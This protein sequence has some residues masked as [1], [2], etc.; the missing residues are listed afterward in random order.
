[1]VRITPEGMKEWFGI[2]PSVSFLN[3]T[4]HLI[5]S[6]GNSGVFETKDGLVVFD[7]PLRQFARRV[8][9]DIR[10]RTQKPVKYLIYSHGHLDHAFGYGP[11][12][13]EIKEKGWDEP[14]VIAHEN[15]M[16]RF[17]K[18]KMLDKYHEW[19]NQMQFASVGGSRQP[20][21]VSSQETLR[22]TVLIKGNEGSYSFSLGDIDF[23]I[24][25]DKGE[26]DDSIWLWVPER[27]T[28]CT[29]DLFISSF[30]NV[31]NPYKVQRYPKDWALALEKM[32]ENDPEFLIPGHGRLIE[33]ENNIYDALSITAEALLFVHDE[34]VN[35]LNEG[36]W[37]EQIYHEMLEIFPEKFK[38]RKM[39]QP[40]YGCY[41][42]AIHA[43]YRLYHG[44][45]T[46]GNPTDLFPAKSH[47]IA[48]E[49]LKLNNE[50][51][52]LTHAQKLFDQ[53]KLQ[54]A[55]HIIDV[56]ILSQDTVRPNIYLEALVLKNKILKEKVKEEST[57][58]AANIMDNYRFE[59][60]KKIIELRKELEK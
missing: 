15:I 49:L 11:F 52:Y 8:Y 5:A 32:I 4:C 29:G 45:Y 24:Y 17:S 21:L 53:G 43:T 36:K 26:S 1:M 35:R 13:K 46:T 41:R 47:D 6:M 7:T 58:I 34:V 54:L 31:G 42:F 37:F 39:L 25:H 2:F 20:V 55:L 18:Y 3:N 56:I 16:N 33:G 12:M 57:F 9:E 28:I 51:N 40:I 48:T 60:R 38:N 50:E 44:W 10:S 30:P 27:R 59:I 23:E 22:P 19:I 14:Q